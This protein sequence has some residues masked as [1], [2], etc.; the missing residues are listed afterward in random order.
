MR[1]RDALV[2]AIALN[3]TLGLGGMCASPVDAVEREWQ[4]VPLG[5]DPE[6][7][8]ARSC[9][10]EAGF[11]DLEVCTAMA[12][13]HLRRARLLGRSVVDMVRAYSSPVKGRT[14]RSWVMMLHP[15][16]PEPRGWPSRLPY[17]RTQRRFEPVLR[18]VERV[19]AGVVPDPCAAT[20]PLHYGGPR[21]M[22]GPSPTGFR[23][24]PTC[25][26]RPG[27]RRAQ[28]FHVRAE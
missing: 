6:L 16:R 15:T 4:G 23:E 11:D 7:W 24:D 13:V 9:V 3:L 19:F 17:A 26:P 2:F 1:S 8:Q 14:A 22:D 25:V 20:E 5:P 21:W 27:Q 28:R 10:G 18:H 12:F